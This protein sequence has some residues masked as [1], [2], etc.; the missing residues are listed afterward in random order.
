MKTFTQ[1]LK[2]IFKPV[3]SFVVA[4][5]LVAATMAAPAEAAVPDQGPT[6]QMLTQLDIDNYKPVGGG[7]AEM[8]SG[9]AGLVII[10]QN[11]NAD[12]MATS[13]SAG[14]MQVMARG[15]DLEVGKWTYTTEVSNG[16]GASKVNHGGG[17][18]CYTGAQVKEGI[19]KR[20]FKQADLIQG[21]LNNGF[22]MRTYAEDG[23]WLS[24]LVQPDKDQTTCQIGNGG[25][26]QM[27]DTPNA[28][29]VN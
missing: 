10:W 6:N 13:N 23:K 2:D 4:M 28:P 19:L 29:A 27:A 12:W 26:F 14:K 5:T 22:T 7:V 8:K 24:V 18:Q 3:A 20:E 9:E 1:S 16:P 11:D 21:V 17:A 25:G 15:T